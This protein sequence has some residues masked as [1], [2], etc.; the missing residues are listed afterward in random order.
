MAGWASGGA[1]QGFGFRNL[2]GAA[3]YILD[4]NVSMNRENEQFWVEC[5]RVD[6]GPERIQTIQCREAKR[7][8]NQLAG[9]FI[10]RVKPPTPYFLSVFHFPLSLD[11]YIYGF[12]KP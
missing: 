3:K 4:I 2:S 1:K 10:L 9:F 12:P 11:I 8:N 7:E 5:R 6:G